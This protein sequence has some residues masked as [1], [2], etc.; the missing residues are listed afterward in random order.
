MT[1]SQQ[2]RILTT[3][4]VFHKVWPPSYPLR[5]FWRLY[6]SANP[7]TQWMSSAKTYKGGPHRLI[8]IPPNISVHR[9]LTQ[10]T[11]NFHIHFTLGI[12]LDLYQGEVQVLAAPQNI[13]QMTRIIADQTMTLHWRLVTSELI[14]HALVALP[15]KNLT[16][17][18]LDS[19]IE[20]LLVF[21]Q[22]NT[23]RQISNDELAMQCHLSQ[24]AMIRL[25]TRHLNRSPQAFFSDIR[26]G[27][28]AAMLRQST[29]LSIEKIAEKTGFYD[30]SHFC[31]RFTALYN[32]TPAAYRKEP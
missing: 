4:R 22:A 9:K 24:P 16:N 28:A 25:F 15:E 31:K 30:R 23:H 27:Q 17:L 20:I 26:L 8:L 13:N 14:T 2:F 1:I 18:Q 29:D 12:P 19:R 11:D 32:I 5:P 10:P 7:G 21:M 6:W 3:Q